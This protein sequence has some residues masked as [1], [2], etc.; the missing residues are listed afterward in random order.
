M[1]HIQLLLFKVMIVLYHIHSLK[2]KMNLMIHTLSHLMAMS[3][4]A[5][6]V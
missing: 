4:L 6:E 3:R 1:H 2:K 5:L